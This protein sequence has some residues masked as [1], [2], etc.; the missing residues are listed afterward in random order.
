MHED[1]G[2]F[3]REGGSSRIKIKPK[4]TD[5][6]AHVYLI[7]KHS[8]VNKEKE[9]YEHTTENQSELTVACMLCFKMPK[10]C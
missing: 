1:R 2:T 5:K 4:K 7:P 10:I 3:D 9:K 8:G 6:A